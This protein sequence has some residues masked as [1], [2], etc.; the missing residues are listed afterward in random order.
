MNEARESFINRHVFDYESSARI[1][2]RITWYDIVGQPLDTLER[3]FRKYQSAT[4]DDIRR[5]GQEYLHPEGLTILVVGNQ[6]LFDR[7][8]ADFGA[9]NTIEIQEEVESE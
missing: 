1:V 7:P 6:D 5:V 2:N 3:D 9:V 8:L 4:H